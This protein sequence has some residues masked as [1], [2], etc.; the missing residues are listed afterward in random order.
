M[1]PLRKFLDSQHHLFA[2]GGKLEVLYP[3]Y[4]ALDTFVFTPADV[5]TGK[6]HV[7]DGLD[8]KCLWER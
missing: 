8:L 6:T 4:E 7:R 1:K 5:T 2:K 3:L